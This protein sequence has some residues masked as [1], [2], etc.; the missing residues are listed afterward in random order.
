ME[1]L[2]YI[3]ILCANSEKIIIKKEIIEECFYI[4]DRVNCN[5]ISLSNFKKKDLD[6]LFAIIEAL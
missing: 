6:L 1:T 5:V 2:N 4:S 3:I